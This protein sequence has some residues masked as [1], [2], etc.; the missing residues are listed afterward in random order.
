MPFGDGHQ[1][2]LHPHPLQAGL[3]EACADDD[4][5]LD[6]L[7]AA[8]LQR[9]TNVFVGDDDNCQFYGAWDIQDAGITPE[10][11]NLISFGVDG[12]DLAGIAM[13]DDI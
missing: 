13:P 1:F 9:C 4:G 7:P 5:S 8:L 10:S 12:V 2:P 11:Q 3:A 6:A